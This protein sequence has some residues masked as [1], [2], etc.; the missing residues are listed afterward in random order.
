MERD[1]KSMEGKTYDILV[2]GGGITGACILRDASLRGLSAALVEKNDFSHAT[3]AATSKLVHGGV[4]YLWNREFKLVWTALRERRIWSEIAPHM[5][6]PLTFLIPTM[7]FGLK[8]RMVLDMALRLY[9]GL[10]YSRNRM[11]DPDKRIPGHKNLN[12]AEA[13]ALEPGLESPKLTGAMVYPDCQ[14]YSPERLGLECILQAAAEGA[15]VANYAEVIEFT[16]EGDRITGAKVRDVATG[17]GELTIKARMTVNA[18]GPWADILMGVL[19]HG[20]PGRRLIRSKGIHL[21]TRS[22][23][24]NHALAILSRSHPFFILP[25]RGYSIIGTTDTVYDGDPDEFHVTEKDIT[26]FLAVVNKGYPRA[27][28][29]RSDVLHFYGGMRPLLERESKVA[30]RK[31]GGDDS[32]LASRA[33]EAYDHEANDGLKGVLSA[34]GGKWTTSRHLA[35]RVVDLAVA[36]LGVTAKACSTDHTSTYGGDVGRFAEFAGR[37]VAKHNTLPTPVVENLAKNYGCRMDDVLALTKDNSRLAE[38]ISD[39]SPDIAAQVVHAVRHEM[40][41]TLEDVLFRRTGLG[42]IGS[43]GDAAI[44]K[45]TNIMAR[46]LG[47]NRGERASQIDRARVKFTPSTEG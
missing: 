11:A 30:R 5:V 18:A 6:G 46:E 23:T 47:W 37:A 43:P 34:I 27:K 32:R 35:E 15:D 42:T 7:G 13:L 3:S 44:A 10:A 33:A 39:R 9:D 31:A 38:R 28:L 22:L 17:G 12:R 26:D 24:Q 21:I 45:I 25:W 36:K 20:K 14:M 1:L 2:V 4:R 8:N 41:L 29:D 19:Q 40:A 16:R